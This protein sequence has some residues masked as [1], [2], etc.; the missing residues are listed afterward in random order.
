MKKILIVLFTF[1]LSFNVCSAAYKP[2]PADK[3][4][5]YKAEVESIIN[6]EVPRAYKQI[7]KIFVD[8]KVTYM[9]ALK[10][11]YNKDLREK[12]DTETV[13]AKFDGPEF[14]IYLDIIETTQKYVDIKNEIPPTSHSFALAEFIHTYLEDNNINYQELSK[15]GRYASEKEEKAFKLIYSLPSPH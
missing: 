7:D 6:K 2:I 5:Q 3:S 4:K 10:D 9:R 1:L 14:S 8:T 11:P 15:C 12:L 13:T